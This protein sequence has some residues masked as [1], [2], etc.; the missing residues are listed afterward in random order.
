[1]GYFTDPS[2][3]DKSGSRVCSMLSACG[4][5]ILAFI[6]VFKGYAGEAVT[7]IGLVLAATWGGYTVNSTAR[8]ITTKGV[9]SGLRIGCGKPPEGG[10]VG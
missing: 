6:L 1:M 10:A 2:T 8:V 3:G 5:V 4:A 9:P 7:V